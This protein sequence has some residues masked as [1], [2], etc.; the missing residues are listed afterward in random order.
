[1]DG[2]KEEYVDGGGGVGMDQDG[3]GEGI[4]GEFMVIDWRV[5]DDDETESEEE[6]SEP[7]EGVDGS[8]NFL[9]WTVC[10]KQKWLSAAA[11]LCMQSLIFFGGR[12]CPMR[13]VVYTLPPS[14]LTPERLRR[15]LRLA[16]NDLG[17][18]IDG[19]HTF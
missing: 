2:S 1:V 13:M 12:L 4:W 3:V 7:P 17:K 5:E 16:R 18:G 11:H 10:S 14:L 8:H 15:S 9:A 19:R 6:A